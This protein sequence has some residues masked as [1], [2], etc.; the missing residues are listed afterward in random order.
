MFD[1]I[2]FAGGGNRCYWQGGFWDAA[3]SVLDFAPKLVVGAS[4]GAWQAAYSLLDLYDQVRPTVIGACGPHRTNFDWRGRTTPKSLFPVAPL[5][6]ELV[7]MTL[8]DAEF[9]RLKLIVDLRIAISRPPRWLPAQ[10]APWV[11]LTGYQLEKRLFH[12]VHPRFGRM[13][14]FEPEFVPVRAMRSRTEL[15]DA[16]MASA[17]VPPIMPILTIGG[18]IALDGGFVDNVPVEPLVPV[19]QAGGRT[20]VLLTRCYRS[21]PHVPGR[22]YVQP[23]EPIP[24]KQFDITDPAGI[25]AAFELGRRD[26]AAFAAAWRRQISASGARRSAIDPGA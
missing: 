3:A 1:A 20:L 10:A 15:V 5:F 2:A 13:L 19:E 8:G 12:P 22:T 23:S 17:T 26:G 4:A 16:I 24:V 21:I 7:S 14:G 25:R 6:H 11:A 9:A 18:R